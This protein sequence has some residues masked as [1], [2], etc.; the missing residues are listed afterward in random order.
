MKRLG[1]AILLVCVLFISGCSIGRRD[2]SISP[3]IITDISGLSGRAS[4]TA[5]LDIDGIYSVL[6]AI[7]SIL[8]LLM[9]RQRLMN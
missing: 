1:Y 4:V 8:Q 6:A 7:Q 9:M 3:Y 2:I 5:Y